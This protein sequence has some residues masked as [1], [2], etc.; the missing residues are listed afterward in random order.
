MLKRISI[1]I[2]LIVVVFAVAGVQA[3]S[4]EDRVDCRGLA[5]ADCQILRDNVEVMDG[6]SSLHFDM[7]LDLGVNLGG[8]MDLLAGERRRRRQV[9]PLIRQ[10]RTLCKPRR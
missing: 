1:L 6:V 9:W 4:I 3:D 7:Q 5:E 2:A 8:L 10:L